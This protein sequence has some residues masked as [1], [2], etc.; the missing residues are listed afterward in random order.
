MHAY[1]LLK[2]GYYQGVITYNVNDVLKTSQ[3]TSQ[4]NPVPAV[5]KKDIVILLNCLGLYS[6]QIT[7]CLKSCA[8]KFYSLVNLK[9]RIIFQNR[10]CLKHEMAK[11]H[12]G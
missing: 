11:W 4:N 9:R 6:N 2:N 3:T 7:K 1:L 5:P 8:Y 10:A 12:Y